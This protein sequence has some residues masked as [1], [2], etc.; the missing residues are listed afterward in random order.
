MRRVTP[1]HYPGASWLIV[2]HDQDIRLGTYTVTILSAILF[3][4]YFGCYHFD[5]RL[6]MA[7]REDQ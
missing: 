2:V 1:C 4:A 7:R 6:F 3:F 5:F